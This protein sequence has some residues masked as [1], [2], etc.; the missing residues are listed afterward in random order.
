MIK[1]IFLDIDGV[2]VGTKAGINFPYPSQ[3]VIA[4]LKNYQDRGIPI[5]LITAKTN[6]S[7]TRQTIINADLNNYHITDAGAVL[8]NPIENKIGMK[9]PIDK[10]VAI[11]ML[12][13]ADRYKVLWEVYTIDN[14]YAQKEVEV[15][16]LKKHEQVL[17]M[18]I[19]RVD[20]I[21]D[22]AVSQQEIIKLMIV[23]TPEQK[24]YL[25]EVLSIFSDR[26]ELQW[27][28]NPKL[29]PNEVLN[30]TAKG[31]SKK[32]GVKEL[33]KIHHLDLSEV[34]GVG[35]TLMD[36]EFI[37]ECGYAGAMGNSTQEFLDKIATK[38]SDH[39]FKGDHVDNDGVL[40]IIKHFEDRGLIEFN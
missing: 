23:Y 13:S 20:N 17:D 35:D 28:G 4:G 36:W 2:I 29:L 30:V 31:I 40:T 7:S 32:S 6:F 18:P 27:G 14:W 25:K 15:E 38:D 26:V 19:V 9:F 37:E 33:A 16:L 12:K 22:L 11:E 21:V 8:I 3:K 34:L 10:N 39:W 1:G 24:S 5:S